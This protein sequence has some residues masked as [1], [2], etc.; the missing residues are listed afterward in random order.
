VDSDER[1]V[2]TLAPRLAGDRGERG[3][4][5]LAVKLALQ[6]QPRE[7][8][9]AVQPQLPEALV[10]EDEPVVVPIREQFAAAQRGS[11]RWL[12]AFGLEAR[13]SRDRSPPKRA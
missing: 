10:L 1:A 4:G 6:Q 8:L 12:S 13:G 9:K 2:P 5:R 7:R 3:F 11:S